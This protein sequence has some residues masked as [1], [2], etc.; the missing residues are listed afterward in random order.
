M[1]DGLLGVLDPGFSPPGSRSVGKHLSTMLEVLQLGQVLNGSF[2]KDDSISC[3]SCKQYLYYDLFTFV[4]VFL[5]QLYKYV[6]S[7][8]LN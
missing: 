8:I 5:I 1:S 6:Q 4:F 3:T 7:R 2:H